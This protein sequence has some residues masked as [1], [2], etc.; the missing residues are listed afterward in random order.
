[1]QYFKE[2]TTHE[3]AKKLYRELVKEH[4]PDAG[5]DLRTMQEINAQYAKFQAGT[6]KEN[7][8]TRQREAHAQNKKSAADFHSMDEVEKKIEQA[9]LFAVGLS[10]VDVELMG[11]WVW[12]SGNTKEHKE[13][14]KAWNTANPEIKFRW[15]NNKKA[16]AFAGVPSFGRKGS[17]LDEIRDTYGSTS[18]TKERTTAG[19]LHA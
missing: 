6:A 8:Y 12:L 7:A 9:I 13:T 19:A 5:G 14:I 10:G 17:T 2:C 3:E 11:L 16:W 4:H 1:M 18:F 15:L